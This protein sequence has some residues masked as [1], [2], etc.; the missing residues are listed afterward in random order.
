MSPTKKE[1][2]LVLF[3]TLTT[4]NTFTKV[5]R[6]WNAS[7]SILQTSSFFFLYLFALRALKVPILDQINILQNERVKG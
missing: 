7:L 1:L 5:G 2:F 3:Y 4:Y 6:A